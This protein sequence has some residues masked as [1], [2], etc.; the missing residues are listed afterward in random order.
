[1]TGIFHNEKSA[2]NKNITI[3]LFSYEPQSSQFV[4]ESLD[5]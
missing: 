5:F 1:M 2:S 3:L 4:L